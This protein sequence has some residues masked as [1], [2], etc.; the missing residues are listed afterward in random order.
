MYKVSRCSPTSRGRLQHLEGGFDIW[1]EASTSGGRLQH[2]EGGFD[3]WREDLE[4][5]SDIW[6]E[7][8]T[9]RG[10]LQHLV[11]VESTTSDTDGYCCCWKEPTTHISPVWRLLRDRTEMPRGWWN[12]ESSWSYRVWRKSRRKKAKWRQTPTS[13]SSRKQPGEDSAQA[14]RQPQLGAEWS[15][16]V[17][18]FAE[19]PV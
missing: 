17:Y 18:G 9:S 8:P 10:R 1:R 16:C 7:A 11:R 5:D 13:R 4:V 14:V 3:I 12:T 6:R 15:Q 2:L 19:D